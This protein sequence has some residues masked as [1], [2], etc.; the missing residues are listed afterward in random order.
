MVQFFPHHS[1]SFPG[2]AHAYRGD[3][4]GRHT[5]DN[6]NDKVS[7]EC[8]LLLVGSFE[9]FCCK[10]FCNVSVA[11]HGLVECKRRLHMKKLSDTYLISS[12]DT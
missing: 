5:Q 4:L 11:L 2:R 3:D 6:D 1:S 7:K 8:S 10:K 12:H 9:E